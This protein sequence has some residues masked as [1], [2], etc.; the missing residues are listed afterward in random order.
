VYAKKGEPKEAMAHL[1]I[2]LKIFTNIGNREKE[3]TALG[4]IGIVYRM[5]GEGDKSM[6]YQQLALKI[7][8]QIGN[9]QGE[10]I[11]LGNIG[12]LYLDEG[13]RGEALGYYQAA[14]KIFEKIGDAEHIKMTEQVIADIK[15][16][17]VVDELIDRSHIFIFYR[18][19]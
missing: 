5:K 17:V 8:R 19:K 16:Q 12:N 1:R 3:A 2:A 6:Q 9:R 15:R 10:A 18:E 11:D 14:L 4:S 7:N 13:K